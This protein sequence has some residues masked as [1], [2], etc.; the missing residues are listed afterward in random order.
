MSES[1]G[2]RGGLPSDRR[3][4][5]RAAWWLAVAWLCGSAVSGGQ[6]RPEPPAPA[7]VPVVQVGGETGGR[8]GRSLPEEPPP[9]QAPTGAPALQPLAVTQLEA[10]SRVG[11][12]DARLVSVRA[13][14]AQPLVDVLFRLVR[15]S[16]FSLV[17]D[18]DVSG[19]FVGDLQ[20]V[21]VR[22]ALEL[23]L[24]PQ[25]LDYAVQ[26]RSIRVFRR[27]METRFFDINALGGRRVA[28][29]WPVASGVERSLP[30]GPEEP[31]VLDEIVAGV[32]ALVTDAGRVHLDRTAGV[33]QVTEYPDR[34]DRVSL[35]LDTVLERLGRQVAVS[36]HVIEVELADSAAAGIDWQAV[37]RAVGAAGRPGSEARPLAVPVAAAPARVL[38][39]LSAQGRVRVL[40]APRAVAAHNEPLWLRVA[41]DEIVWLPAAHLDEA[42]RRQGSAAETPQVVSEGVMLAVT[43]HIA[44]DGIVELQISPRVAERAGTATSRAAAAPAVLAVREAETVV[45]A[46]DGE[47]VL[48]AGLIRERPTVVRRRPPVL[49]ALP[50]LGGRFERAVSQLVRTELVVLLTATIVTPGRI[51]AASGVSTR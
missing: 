26:D 38:E 50:L 19:V 4:G 22:Q 12:L 10:R 42:S 14:E 39:A 17:P 15:E 40:A 47:P 45:R 29:R 20:N 6:A 48:V 37:W 31:D 2:W 16:G 41:T 13:P 30:P 27:R 24:R 28:R 36:A 35:Y 51:A 43:P 32:R 3:L 25:G 33:L 21:T 8:L 11:D 1:H 7:P 5:S 46:A 23:V 49:G 18:P 44:S 34:L 9:G